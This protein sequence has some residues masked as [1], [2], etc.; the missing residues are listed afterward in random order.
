MFEQTTSFMA[1]LR[2]PTHIIELANPA[3]MTLIGHRDVIGKTVGEALSEVVARGYIELLDGVY[4]SGEAQIE[5]GANYRVQSVAGGAMSARYVNLRH[6]PIKADNGEVTGI[7]IEGSDVTEAYLQEQMSRKILE[8]QVAEST[9]ALRQ[10]KKNIR[11]VFETSHQNQ[12]LLTA[13][14]KIIYVNRTSLASIKSCLED[15]VGKEFW[16]TLWFTGTPGIPAAVRDAV[17]RVA[18]GRTVTIFMELNLPTGHRA[19]NFSMRPVFDEGGDVFA[20]VP[21]AVEITARVQAEEGWRRAL[22]LRRADDRKSA[23]LALGDRLRELRDPDAIAIA[24]GVVL[25]ETLR[26]AQAAYAIVLDDG[27]S[28]TVLKPWL[29]DDGVFS[30][31]GTRRFSDFG[32][33]VGQLHAGVAVV[34][35]DTETDERT[36]DRVENFVSAG[37]S[38]FVNM[39]LMETGRMV[40][41]ILVFD[42]RPRIWPVEDLAF[43]RSVADRTWSA[44][45]RAAA[46]AELR[47][48]NLDLERKIEERT[49]ERDRVW[50]NSQDLLCILDQNGIFQAA[51]PAWFA[52]LGWHPSEIVGRHH[53]SVNHLD[54]R[55]ASEAVLLRAA[56]V[57]VSAY[58]T[59]LL[60]KDGSD[61]WISWVATGEENLVYASG[62][63]VTDEK[64]AQADLKATQEA[65]RQSQK[66]E[67]V[68]QLTGGI[69]HD[70]NNLLGGIS[71][72]LELLEIRMAQGRLADA[73][74]YIDAAQQS[75]RR[76][77]SL[78]QR[79]LAFS[80][81]QTLDPKPTEVDRLIAGV[82]D[83]IR[84]TVGPNIDL[85]VVK[86]GEIWLTKID[87]SQLENA[88]LN[89]CINARDAMPKGG[90]ITIETANQ[91]LGERAGLEPGLV[92]GPYVSLSVTDTGTGMAGD[93]I[94]QA[95]DPFFTTKPLGQGTGLGL[96]MIHGFVRQSGGQIRIASELGKGTIVSI[97]LPRF[98][99]QKAD[100]DEPD[101]PDAAKAGRGETV[102]VIDD[103]PAL[104]MLMIEVLEDTGYRT[105]Q[106]CDGPEGLKILNS[107]ARI[108]LL[109]TDVGLPG[110]M[111][112][113]QVADAARTT[114]PDLKVL[115][116]TGYAEHSVIGDGH[117]DIGMQVI[118]KPFV[119]AA[120]G[121]KVR[122][123]IETKDY[124]PTILL[125]KTLSGRE[126][127]GVSPRL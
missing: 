80:R 57:N 103:V 101:A 88:L 11:T 51:N 16:D 21:E 109:L 89:L 124:W 38:A 97:Y 30:L 34:V 48:L 92:P 121:N 120:L 3:Y 47:A 22:E 100:A 9:A 42:D 33:Y 5:N 31:E 52:I 46:E 18:C 127:D 114:R 74:R 7:F 6:Q 56:R 17:A 44:L 98:S 23:L 106:A 19:Y 41:M 111:N 91:W 113:R 62:R 13:E 2:G 64:A 72:N 40:A 93:V 94:A 12:G 45:A 70:F 76:A 37:I 118:T 105:L 86:A 28:A 112:G 96:S 119:L 25:G 108:D 4:K 50:S 69:A 8:Q 71:G 55:N 99:G 35:T 110:G 104:R 126:A 1:V 15:V 123:M 29:R 115:F 20:M 65:L 75:A 77:A 39:P 27:D 61:R 81:R 60:H 66:M 79:L 85:E 32:R 102:L 36:I 83:L 24:A 116:V 43:M 59:R 117:L 63:D 49:V 82:A 14:G 58:E 73:A 10:A 90:R 53:L 67:A 78:T 26:V 122:E 84:R 107:N 87:P 95:F 68:G 54:H 125:K